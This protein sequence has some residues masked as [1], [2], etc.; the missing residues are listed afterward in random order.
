MPVTTTASPSS[1]ADRLQRYF[2]RELLAKILP[3]LVLEQFAWKEPLPARVGGKTMRF[4]RFAAPSTADIQTL[5]EGTPMAISAHKQLSSEYVDVDLAQYGQVISISDIATSVELFNLLEQAT[6]QQA[7]DAALHC[8][9]IVRN[10]LKIHTGTSGGE[11]VRGGI[12]WRFG[13]RG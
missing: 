8:D 1:S 2:S 7:Q 13:G 9:T 10:E 5:T 4:T 12:C 11:G 3:L 6:L